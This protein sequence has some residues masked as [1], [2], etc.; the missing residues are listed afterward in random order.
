LRDFTIVTFNA[1]LLRALGGLIEPAPFVGE[2]RNAMPSLLSACGAD[3]ILLQ[4][5]YG[6]AARRELARAL[7]FSAYSDNRRSGLMA[8]SASSI[9]SVLVPFA[10]TTPEERLFDRK[11]V[12]VVDSSDVVACNIHMTA[13]GVRHPESSAANAIRARQ[14]EQLLELAEARRARMIAGDLN[15]GPGVSEANYALFEKGGW[16]DVHALVHP[17][18]GDVTW[19]PHNPLNVR[20]PHRRSPPQRVDHLFVRGDDLRTERVVPRSSEIVFFEPIVATAAGLMTPSDHYALRVTLAL[21][22]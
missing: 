4:E 20:G 12:L 10:A 14:I 16:I 1:G 21:A 8:L 19:D 11:G 3:L 22:R 9:E 2:R 13:G 18:S 15:A 5:V 6:E 7:P 17:G